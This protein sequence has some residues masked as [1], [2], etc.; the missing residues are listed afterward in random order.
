MNDELPNFEYFAQCVCENCT[1]NDW[2][3]PSYCDVLRKAEKMPF[4]D[5]QKA[6]ERNDGDIRKVIRWIKRKR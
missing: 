1:S 4:E 5:I 3:C 2:Y 6:Y